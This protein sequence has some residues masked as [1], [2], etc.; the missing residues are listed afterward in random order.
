[1]RNGNGVAHTTHHSPQTNSSMFW[2][3]IVGQIRLVLFDRHWS[4]WSSWHVFKCGCWEIFEIESLKRIMSPSTKDRDLICWTLRTQLQAS[5]WFT[6]V[7]L[8]KDLRS[9]VNE[10]SDSSQTWWSENDNRPFVDQHMIIWNTFDKAPLS[11]RWTAPYFQNKPK[12]LTNAEDKWE[13]FFGAWSRCK[14]MHGTWKAVLLSS[15]I[16]EC[17]DVSWRQDCN[18]YSFRSPSVDLGV[19]C[20]TQRMQNWKGMKSKSELKCL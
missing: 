15:R 3:N 20:Q 13:V 6:E 19:I 2:L 16:I 4:T 11:W 18:R 17:K 12:C 14:N 5:L 10:T 9:F 7:V 8:F 1:M